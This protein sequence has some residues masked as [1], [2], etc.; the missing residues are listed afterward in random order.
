MMPFSQKPSIW[1]RQHSRSVLLALILTLLGIGAAVLVGWPRYQLHAA[2]RALNRYAFAEA[3]EHM[4]RY[5]KV[6][7]G[8]AAAHLLAAQIARRRD[9][10]D[11]AEKHLA[12]AVQEHGMTEAISLERTLLAAQQG[13]FESA[14]RSLWGRTGPEYPEAV[15]VLEALAKGYVNHF[16]QAQELF[17]LNL[18]L[19]RDPNHPYA[20]PARARAW[21]DRAAHGE[22][23]REE[24]AL[25]DYEKAVELNPT[26]EARLGLA[27]TLY[28][29]GRVF[30]ALTEYEQLYQS[31]PKHTEVI[32]G[33]ACCRYSVHQVKEAK[34]LLRTVL[35]SQP[36]HAGA[37]LELG[38][39][40]LHEGELAE[41]ESLL[42]QAVAH[43][44]RFRPEPLRVLVRCLE[45]ADKPEEAGKVADELARREAEVIELERMSS[46][47][48]KD[49]RNVALRY[50][51]AL[52]L[53]ALGREHDGA[54]ALMGVI[55]L[56]PRHGPA[57]ES[58]ADYF[59]R[60]GQTDRAQVHRRIAST[61]AAA[62]GNK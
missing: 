30:D 17:C 37:L 60:K 21:E 44:P 40:L 1:L 18:L 61:P 31:Q 62:T 10:Y 56:D 3:Q 32:F 9:D 14:E 5:F 57:H 24:D 27:G 42:R 49:P 7:S 59:D 46:R 2:K 55:D 34:E 23:E 22:K 13:N 20:L 11:Q 35:K 41:A 58:L 47:A 53:T 25:H 16:R 36:E 48:G 12:A 39:V 43:S 29:V 19:E 15:L 45:A 50:E 4:D 8:D 6:R 28:R 51:I 33:L 26:F 38:R 52:K 54:A